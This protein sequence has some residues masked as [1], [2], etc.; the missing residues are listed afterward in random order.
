MNSEYFSKCQNEILSQAKDESQQN[1]SGVK[2]VSEKSEIFTKCQDEISSL[3]RSE[4]QK[5][6]SGVKD[7]SMDIENF[8]KSQ[9]DVSSQK[10][11]I[12]YFEG[13]HL[14]LM[15]F[16]LDEKYAVPWDFR[17]PLEYEIISSDDS[18]PDHVL[19]TNESENEVLMK[20][21]LLQEARSYQDPLICPSHLAE[22]EHCYMCD[23]MEVVSFSD[24]DLITKIR[25]NMDVVK[26]YDLSLIHI[27]EPT[28]PY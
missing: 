28:R 19:T 9:E 16:Y 5:N 6:N 18:P 4:T 17:F 7:V 14:N 20:K 27:S 23:K 13:T 22:I 25:A 12:D 2:D 15:D 24:L 26:I 8:S 1:I 11:V 3:D 21:I 10:D